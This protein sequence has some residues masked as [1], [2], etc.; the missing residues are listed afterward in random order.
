VLYKLAQSDN[1]LTPHDT[2]PV[3]GQWHNAHT[4]HMAARQVLTE[5]IC[6]GEILYTPFQRAWMQIH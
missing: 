3:F 1:E 6:V 4:C 2:C 5:S